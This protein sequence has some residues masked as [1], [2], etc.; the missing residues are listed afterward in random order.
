MPTDASFDSLLGQL[1]LR[2][3]TGASGP[4]T[5]TATACDFTDAELELPDVPALDEDALETR[6]AERLRDVATRRER[7]TGELIAVGDEVVLDVVASANGRLLPFSARSNWR[8]EVAADPS[9]PGFFEALVGTPVGNSLTVDVTL[10]DDS[11]VEALRGVEARFL[12]DVKQTFEVE[13]LEQSPEDWPRRLGAPD[14]E[15]L[16]ARLADELEEEADD[17]AEAEVFER[18]LDV[19]A[20][21]ADV[22]VPRELVDREVELAWQRLER[23][24]LVGRDFTREDL[25]DALQGWLDD[26]GTRLQAERRLRVTAGLAAV[27]RQYGLVVDPDDRRELEATLAEAAG[28]STISFAAATSELPGA[29]AQLD[30]LALRLL[31]IDTVR[32]EF[33]DG[34]SADTNSADS[35]DAAQA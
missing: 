8:V 21:R 26:E 16:L 18:L 5:L 7:S 28:L 6:L 24:L 9:L 1:A 3:A 35:T 33:F 15:T 17:E 27:V 13:E 20:E 12:V 31:A 22:D 14:L 23:P 2:K 29:D 32:S 25:D 10:P 30:A 19:V 11:P 4:V 34:E